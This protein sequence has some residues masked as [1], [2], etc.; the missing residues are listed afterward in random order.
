MNHCFVQF[1]QYS[2]SLSFQSSSHASKSLVSRSP[3]FQLPLVLGDNY[4]HGAGGSSDHNYSAKVSDFEAVDSVSARSSCRS[5]G[6]EGDSD[7]FSGIVSDQFSSDTE[8]EQEKS[9]SESYSYS[10]HESGLESDERQFDREVF[11]TQGK[12]KID[13]ADDL[14]EVSESN[15]IQATR[16]GDIPLVKRLIANGCSLDAVDSNR[17][18]ALHVAC[19]LGRLEIARILVEG[20][21]NVD[22]ASIQGQTPLHEACV[23][24]RYDVLQ[25][26]ISEVVDLDMVDANGLSAA[27][28]CAMNGEVKCLS[29][30]CNQVCMAMHASNGTG[31][32]TLAV[33]ILA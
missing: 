23:N 3:A 33:F 24:G 8:V 17:R 14:A 2:F 26:L 32:V 21:A 7:S 30:L 6:L 18:T 28:Y 11:L 22:A 19:S 9:E 4:Y 15:L 31:T 5:P 16:D 10:E 29:L 27:H 12:S 25:E 13:E 20:G 1:E